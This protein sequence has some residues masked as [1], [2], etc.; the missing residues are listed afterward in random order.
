MV[1]TKLENFH[2]NF[3]NS[4]FSVDISLISAKSLGNVPN[5]PPQEYISQNYDIGPGLFFVLCRHFNKL[6]FHYYLRFIL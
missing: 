5:N 3:L 2:I 1:K 4:D 6:F